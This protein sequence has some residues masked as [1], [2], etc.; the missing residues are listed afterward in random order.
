[1]SHLAP[2][3]LDPRLVWDP[4]A[5]PP[6]RRL[7]A[8]LAIVPLQIA[9]DLAFDLVGHT[10]G[11]FHWHLAFACADSLEAI[12][13][14]GVLR[15]LISTPQF[16][17]VAQVL[18]YFLA[19]AAGA[20]LSATL[21]AFGAVH[22][23]GQESYLQQWQVW[24][25]GNF[26]GSAVIAPVVLGGLLLLL[27]AWIF[28]TQRADVRSLLQLPLAVL[29]LLVVAAFRL[30]PRWSTTLAATV[31][32]LCAWLASLGYGPF[33]VDAA[34]VGAIGELQLFLGSLA[35][36]TF[37]LATVLLE[38]SGTL[39]R[40]RTSDER[41]R[42]FVEQSS[43]AVWRVELA[44]PMPI[45]LPPAAQADWLRRE[46]P[47]PDLFAEHLEKAARQGYRMEDLRA[48]FRI[49]G[50][51]V[52]YT[53]SFAGVVENGRRTARRHGPA[54]GGPG[55]RPRGHGLGTAGY[56]RPACAGHGHDG[57]RDPGD[58][59]AGDCGPEPAR[60]L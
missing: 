23:L 46:L 1:M 26:L 14:A 43:E 6:A 58:H 40:L 56:A 3:P 7:R 34:H 53:T 38:Q 19:A 4:A 33:S 15:S 9:V 21:G 28:S 49:E 8:W 24:W 27:V 13:A 10:P 22:G 32:L 25:A 20:A 44:K 55:A 48:D 2:R 30:P 45:G 17:R 11:A 42:N 35:L 54:A 52:C 41:Y 37:L 16:A 51:T 57:A 29:A 59:P 18:K 31:T 47:W 60:A 36:F 50:R 5:M 39:Q 12:L